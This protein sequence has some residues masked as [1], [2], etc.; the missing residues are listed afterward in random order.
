V[1]AVTKTLFWKREAAAF[2]EILKHG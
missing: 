2:R 1:F